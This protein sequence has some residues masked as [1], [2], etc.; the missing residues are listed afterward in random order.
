MPPGA[1]PPGAFCRPAPDHVPP[2][3]IDD[4]LAGGVGAATVD[5][6][7]QLRL[8][9]RHA[10]GR[11]LS[12]S[13]RGEAFLDRLEPLVGDPSLLPWRSAHATSQ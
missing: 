9:E 10:I 3:R 6:L 5:R 11:A 2:D 1:A 4:H 7:S 12:I 8:V 13:M